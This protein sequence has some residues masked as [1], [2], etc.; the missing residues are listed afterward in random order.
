MRFVLKLLVTL[1]MGT[2]LGA[3]AAP[4]DTDAVEMRDARPPSHLKYVDGLGYIK[5]LS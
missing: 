1:A 2:V 4:L 5:V 3:I